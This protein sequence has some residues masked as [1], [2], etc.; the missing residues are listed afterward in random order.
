MRRNAQRQVNSAQV[1]VQ[2][3]T[4][5]AKIGQRPHWAV[6]ATAHMPIGARLRLGRTQPFTATSTSAGHFLS[7]PQNHSLRGSMTRSS[8]TWR[9]SDGS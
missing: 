5:P 1:E 7:L 4:A 6:D 9:G 8:G 3:L 2:P